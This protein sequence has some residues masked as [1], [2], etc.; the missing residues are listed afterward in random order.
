MQRSK[1]QLIRSPRRRAARSQSA[2]QCRLLWRFEVHRELKSV[3]LLD[4]NISDLGSLEDFG[5]VRSSLPMHGGE[6]G[7]VR[8]ESCR[9]PRALLRSVGLRERARAHEALEPSSLLLASKAHGVVKIADN[10]TIR[11]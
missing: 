9:S 6:I 8:Q 5:D 11:E 4:P 2:I 3:R 10:A 1:L 7:A